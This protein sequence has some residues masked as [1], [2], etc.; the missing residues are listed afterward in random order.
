MKPFWRFS[1]AAVAAFLLSGC[2][3]LSNSAM[4]SREL[5]PSDQGMQE[6]A[7]QNNQLISD[8]IAHRDN[9]SL[10]AVLK[11]RPDIASKSFAGITPLFTAAF[12]NNVDA[13]KALID[14]G[15]DVNYTTAFGERPL[16]R[17]Q[18]SNGDAVAE[19][20]KQHGAKNGPSRK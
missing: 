4:A 11:Q 2:H 18:T 16:D 15:A 6:L 1:A 3:T 12:F 10:K 9:D 17:A 7:P 8:M 20:L 14:A 13:A 19:L 5:T